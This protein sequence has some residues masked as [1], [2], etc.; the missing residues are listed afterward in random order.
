MNRKIKYGISIVILMLTITCCGCV[1]PKIWENLSRDDWNYV[2]NNNSVMPSIIRL[3]DNRLM[4][5]CWENGNIVSYFSSNEGLNFTGKMILI[6][7]SNNYNP[8]DPALS[9]INGEIYLVTSPVYTNYRIGTCKSM[10]MRAKDDNTFNFSVITNI[11]HYGSGGGPVR[12]LLDGSLI[13]SIYYWQNEHVEA[14]KNPISYVTVLRSIDGG[15]SW[16]QGNPVSPTNKFMNESDIFESENHLTMI[17]RSIYGESG[18][19]TSSY[20]NGITWTNPR[21]IGFETAG[22]PIFFKVSDNIILLGYRN[23]LAKR[24]CLRVSI[25][26]GKTWS[27]EYVIDYCMCAYPSFITLNDGSILVAYTDD[28]FKTDERSV[29]KERKF[30]INSRGSIKW[31]KW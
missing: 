31:I 11:P 28:S 2:N 9:V 26:S 24:T 14:I 1:D 19:L 4:M 25:D 3:A 22:G 18:I 17:S 5:V 29:I 13:V 6:S 23:T 21:E 7:S 10:I 30:N 15:N 8:G 27:R 16:I 12:K 20:D